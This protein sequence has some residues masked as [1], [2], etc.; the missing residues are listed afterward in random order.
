[1]LPAGLGPGD[2]G[3]GRFFEEHPEARAMP[4]RDLGDLI[5]VEVF[6]KK[7]A[8][9]MLADSERLLAWRPDLVVREEGEYAGPAVAALAGVP[10]VDHSWGPMRSSTAIDDVA[11]C[12]AGLWDRH[13]L[14][15][16][17]RAGFFRWLYLDVAPPTLQFSYAADVA[18]RRPIRPMS[19]PSSV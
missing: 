19:A 17:P 12:L 11:P 8:P 15:P 3:M 7:L 10:W 2:W 14:E 6:A 9:A 16:D 1:L 18:N 13:G 5:D 4:A